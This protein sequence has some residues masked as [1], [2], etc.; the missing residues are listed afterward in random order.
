ML[1][2]L[3][4]EKHIINLPKIKRMATIAHNWQAVKGTSAAEPFSEKANA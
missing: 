2:L 4:S 1:I 3:I